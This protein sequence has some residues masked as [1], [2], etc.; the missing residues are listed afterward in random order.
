MASIAA[1]FGHPYTSQYL[2]Q[3]SHRACCNGGSTQL[4][5]HSSSSVCSCHFQQMI[6]AQQKISAMPIGLMPRT[7]PSFSIPETSLLLGAREMRNVPYSPLEIRHDIKDLTTR[8]LNPGWYLNSGVYPSHHPNAFERSY[9]ACHG[10]SERFSPV[11][12]ASGARRKNATRETTSTLKAWLYEHRKNPYPTK[13][14]KIMLAIL[15]KMTLTQVSTWFANA[16]RRLKK[17][18]KMTWSP[19]NRCNDRKDNEEYSEDEDDD[20]DDDASIKLLDDDVNVKLVENDVTHSEKALYRTTTVI[21]SSKETPEVNVNDL[22]STSTNTADDTTNPSY[23]FHTRQNRVPHH[24]VPSLPSAIWSSMQHSHATTENN[25]RKKT[26]HDDSPVNS[27]RKW[28]DGCFDKSRG[29]NHTPDT[30]PHTPPAD[31]DRPVERIQESTESSQITKKTE[32][33]YSSAEKDDHTMDD[34]IQNR[35]TESRDESTTNREIDAALAL[36]TLFGARS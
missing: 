31:V 8:Q 21:K 12:L 16:R 7:A 22:S 18:N 30:P 11:D 34:Q 17:E 28:V 4:T 32:T 10:Y 24:P 26:R 5:S 1:T 3:T 15:T 14:E 23:M 27:L 35:P 36:T 6:Q 33:K 19:R 20:D 13:G 9:L 29:E 25:R 2:M